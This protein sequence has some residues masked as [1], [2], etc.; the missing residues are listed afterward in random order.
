MGPSDPQM[1]YCYRFGDV[2]FDEARMGLSV[3]GRE[4]RVERRPLQ[5]LRLLLRCTDETVTRA[6]LFETVWHG[7]PTVDNVLASAISK[8]RKALGAEAARIVSVPRV[9]Y[10]LRG[11]VERLARE[12]HGIEPMVLRAGQAVPGRPDVLLHE[13]LGPSASRPVW[14][15]RRVRTGASRV[16]KFAADQPGLDALRREV[17]ISRLLHQ[18]FGECGNFPHLID[19]NF[20]RS[21]YWVQWEDGGTDLA[22]WAGDSAAFAAAPVEQRVA[23]FVQIAVAVSA[24]HRAGVLHQD[25]KPSNVLVAPTP[26]KDGWR[27]RIADFGSGRVLDVDRLGVLGITPFDMS[28][29]GTLARDQLS[30]W[31]TWRPSCWQE[32]NRVSPRISMRWA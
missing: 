24:A 26:L 32:S 22:R 13:C 14:R 23:W 8:L 11:P 2:E 27:F 1:Q 3:G 31:C 5:I 9:G 12:A 7:R 21:P 16:Y 25:L 29:R 15:A 18:S 10:R 17:T 19:W 6:E 28:A 4:R 20:E 30:K